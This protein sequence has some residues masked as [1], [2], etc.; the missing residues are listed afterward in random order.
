MT[1]F[2]VTL[3]HPD[4][5]GQ[6]QRRVDSVHINRAS[7]EIRAAQ[8]TKLHPYGL[9]SIETHEI[10]NLS[11]DDQIERQNLSNFYTGF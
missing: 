8:L 11:D 1:V 5:S 4:F 7:A 6:I 10:Q 3:N 9:A 2:V